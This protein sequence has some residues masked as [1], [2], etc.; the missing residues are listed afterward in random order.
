MMLI[1]L[2]HIRSFPSLLI[3]KKHLFLLCFLKHIQIITHLE[4]EPKTKAK[5]GTVLEKN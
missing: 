5:K 2:D 4:V 3:L 1:L